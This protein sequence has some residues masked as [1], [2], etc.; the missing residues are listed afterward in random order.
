LPG[1]KYTGYTYTI[2][3][4]LG[5][6]EKK[7]GDKEEIETRCK[8]APRISLTKLVELL[9]QT[10]NGKKILSPKLHPSPTPTNRQR[11]K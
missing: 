10:E 9:V 8:I 7:K 11:A 2:T 5:R 3:K 6:E 1:C 4:Q